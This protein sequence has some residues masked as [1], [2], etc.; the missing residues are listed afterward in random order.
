MKCS[1]LTQECRYFSPPSTLAGELQIF[2]SA[3]E[4]FTVSLKTCST[5]HHC[6]GSL[7]FFFFFSYSPF[8]PSRVVQRRVADS[9]SRGA[10]CAREWSRRSADGCLSAPGSEGG[11][12]GFPPSLLAAWMNLPCAKTGDGGRGAGGGRGPAEQFNMPV[13]QP[14][15]SPGK[16]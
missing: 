16:H 13:Y 3:N 15:G 5:L 9:C 4:F 14:K 6:S 12:G 2:I 11:E 8:A 7:P 10:F 1:R